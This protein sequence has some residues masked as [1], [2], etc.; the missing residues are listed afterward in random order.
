MKLPLALL[1]GTLAVTS[2]GGAGW[3]RLASL[4]EPN[5]GFVCGAVGGRII[6][7]GGT[8]WKDDS[9]RWLDRIWSYDPA[10]GAWREG[11]RL[12]S[13]LAYAVA[14]QARDSL[15]LAGGSDGLRTDVTFARLDG[16]LRHQAVAGIQTHRVYAT[17]AMLR[18]KLYV[19]GGATDQ[20]R[21]ETMTNTGF[22]IALDSGRETRIADLPGPGLVNAAAAACAG[23]L[24]VFGGARWDPVAGTVANLADAHAYSPDENRWQPLKPLPSPV[25][26]LTAVVLDERR[27]LLAGGYKNDVEEFT[28]ETFLYDVQANAYRP[29]RALPYAALVGLVKSGDWIYCLAGEDRKRH[30]T[31]AV[32]RLRWRELLADR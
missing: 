3:E 4:P 11:G 9:K 8:N 12:P 22:A 21:L 6:V 23:R 19:L 28:A 18:G 17:G 15:W 32:W 24:F 26:G 13:P 25:R 2:A 16:S 29:T 1:A 5:G 30:R 14:G 20:A 10:V 7:A 27:L 31:D